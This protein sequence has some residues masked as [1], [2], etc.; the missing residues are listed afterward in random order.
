VVTVGLSC[1]VLA[2]AAM[3]AMRGG[4]VREY[5][6]G[7]EDMTPA[8]HIEGAFNVYGA[9]VDVVEAFPGTFSY[10]YGRSLVPLFLGWVPRALWPG[11]PYPF[12][13]FATYI[14]GQTLEQ[15][16]ASIAVGLTGEGYGNFGL[17][18]GF[19]WGA[20]LGLACAWGDA[21]LT[22]IRTVAALQLQLAGIGAVWTAMIVRGGVPEMFYMGLGVAMGPV[23]LALLMKRW[24]EESRRAVA[25]A[26]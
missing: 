6:G 24:V 1:V 4:D 19:L 26:R 23:L 17:A 14:R 2:W 11:K 21:A 9:L 22:K 18:G 8:S 15:R 5:E 10:E 25:R 16:D 20:L 13:L 7:W 12:S 3:S